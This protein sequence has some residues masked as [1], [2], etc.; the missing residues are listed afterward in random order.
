MCGIVAGKDFSYSPEKVRQALVTIKSR[1]PDKSQIKQ[2]NKSTFMGFNLLGLAS[3]QVDWLS[4]PFTNKNNT[5]S[6]CVNGEIYNYKTLRFELEQQGCV[7]T[8]MSDCEV[9]LFG[10]ELYGPDFFSRLNGE[11]ALVAYDQI[12]DKW[13]CAVDRVGTKPL[14]YFC[15]QQKFLIASSVAALKELGVVVK[16]NDK[17]CLFSFNTSCVPTGQS[18]FAD[19]KTIPPGHFLEVCGQFETKVK[20]YQ[21]DINSF[22]IYGNEIEKNFEEAVRVRIPKYFK[23][24]VALSGGIDS[25]IVALYLKKSNVDFSCY[26]LDFSNSHYSEH[27]DIKIFCDDN[28][29][30]T[31]YISASEGLIRNHFPASIV[32]AENS[33]INPHSAG[34]LILNKA[35]AAAG[36]RVCFTGDGADELFW[37]YDHFHKDNPFQFVDDSNAIGRLYLQ[38]LKPEHYSSLLESNLLNDYQ[39]IKN[40]P[41]AQDLYYHYWFNEYGLKILGDSQSAT[42]SIEYR[43]PFVDR[44]LLA[45]LKSKM[46]REENF[47]SK[48]VLRN[49]IGKI[50]PKK[51]KVLKKPFTAPIMTANW[52]PLFER[53]VLTE[54][55]K[56]LD[57]FDYKKLEQYILRLRS[58]YI[59]N[60]PRAHSILLSQILSIGILNQE[61][62]NG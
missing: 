45:S 54:K 19:I 42:Q 46:T 15:N 55:F 18:L 28:Q 47:P 7:F 26:S 56:A 16:L 36:H 27:E 33:V 11:F 35:I 39:T 58:Q 31:T 43:Y 10:L 13:L 41:S 48:M 32:N 6:V 8:T 49:L 5:L 53:Y 14:K 61:L 17:N 62:C 60:S 57:L 38:I 21:A 24:A 29:I 4:Q 37:G 2:I 34:K 25:S 50:D 3:D 52:V 44:V 30:S 40:N 22:E 12:S 23:P 9:V 1:G 51:A 20:A 59:P